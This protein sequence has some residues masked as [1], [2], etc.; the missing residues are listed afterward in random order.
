LNESEFSLSEVQGKTIETF[1][2]GQNTTDFIA[3]WQ[4]VKQGLNVE[5]V[6]KRKTKFGKEKWWRVNLT[7]ICDEEGNIIKTLYLA[8][9]ITK[10]KDY[11]TEITEQSELLKSQEDII[12]QDFD[13][14]QN[15]HET[16]AKNEAAKN[17]IINAIDQ[18]FVRLMLNTVGAITETNNTFVR[19]TGYSN[20][21]LIGRKLESLIPEY[22][23]PEQLKLWQ[24]VCN[25]NTCNYE[26]NIRKID[27]EEIWLLMNYIPVVN[28]LDEVI[29]VSIL[30]ADNTVNA[31]KTIQLKQKLDQLQKQVEIEQTQLLEAA[32]K[33]KHA[34]EQLNEHAKNHSESIAVYQNEITAMHNKWSNQ[35][36][37]A[38]QKASQN[39]DSLT[40]L[41]QK[42]GTL[43]TKLQQKENEQQKT[44]V[45]FDSETE[46]LYQQWLN[47]IENIT[48]QNN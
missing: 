7:P 48:Q 38:E 45:L 47:H 43:E 15:L 21:E 6:V 23:I 39:N 30:A 26:Q 18:V 19:L 24:N 27:G 3:I 37:L 17:N 22:L 36:T 4:S 14:L 42:V 2:D 34:E 28:E 41:N 10:Q 20:D 40:A 13:N 44:A 11:E 31:Q 9:D 29:S 32:N 12:K 35:L 8:N 46:V 5:D 16:I 33:L 25:N 1:F